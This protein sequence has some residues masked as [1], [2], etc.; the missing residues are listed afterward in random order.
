M[1]CSIPAIPPASTAARTRYGLASQPATRFSMRAAFGDRLST[2]TAADL[3]SS[4]HEATVGAAANPTMRLNE[5]MFGQ[6]IDVAA[7]MVAIS[8]P[9]QCLVSSDRS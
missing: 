5:L 3:S 7:G 4:P 2:R 9:S 6:K 8:P 1:A